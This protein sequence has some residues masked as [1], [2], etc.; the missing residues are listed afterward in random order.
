MRYVKIQSRYDVT[1]T[2]EQENT[3][4]AQT[5]DNFP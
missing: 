4:K 1:Y 5:Q 3:V 2:L